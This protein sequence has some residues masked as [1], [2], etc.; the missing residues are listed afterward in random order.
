MGGGQLD[1]LIRDVRRL[2]GVERAGDQTDAQ[3]LDR[4]ITHQ[5]EAAFASLMG[6]HGPLVWSVCREIL[7]DSHDAEDAFQATFLVL[8]RKA[9]SI[10]KHTS[11]RSWLYGVAYRIAVQAKVNARKRRSHERQGIEME[12]VQPL[13]TGPA[14]NLGP[15]LHDV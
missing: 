5:E 3:L 1:I 14:Q 4:F 6:R 11:L 9:R 15:A 13:H 7:G 8:V 10:R 2:T 12:G